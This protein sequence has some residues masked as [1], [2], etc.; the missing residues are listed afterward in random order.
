MA[1]SEKNRILVYKNKF[2][3]VDKGLTKQDKKIIDVAVKK[4]VRE[5]GEML[6]LLGRE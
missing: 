4:F 1:R 5:Y 3:I 6:R 2:D